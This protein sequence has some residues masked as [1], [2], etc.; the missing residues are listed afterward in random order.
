MLE[1]TL[2]EKELRGYRMHVINTW[3][4]VIDTP[5]KRFPLA[6]AVSRSFA[7]ARTIGP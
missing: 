4:P 6:L 1:A 2:T 3:P 7:A 5:L